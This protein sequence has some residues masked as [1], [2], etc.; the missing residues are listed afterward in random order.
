MWRQGYGRV[1]QVLL[2]VVWVLYTPS[3]GWVAPGEGRRVVWCVGGGP[4]RTEDSL[5]LV[6]EGKKMLSVDI[7]SSLGFLLWAGFLFLLFFF[8]FFVV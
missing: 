3:A 8:S 1:I 7:P 6:R 2:P 4:V 5:V